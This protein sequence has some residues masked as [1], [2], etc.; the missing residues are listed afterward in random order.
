VANVSGE[1]DIERAKQ[2]RR[3]TKGVHSVDAKRELEAAAVRL[4]KRGARKLAKVGKRRR[5]PGVAVVARP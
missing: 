4:E 1:R 3:L 5:K 2:M